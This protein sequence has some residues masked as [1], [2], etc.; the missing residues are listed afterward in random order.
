LVFNKLKINLFGE[1]RSF[2]KFDFSIDELELYTAI[3]HKLKIPIHKAFLDPFFYH[4]LG[5]SSISNF[6]D[7]KGITLKGLLNSPKNQIEIWFKNKKV[8]KLA[9][10]TFNNEY[11]LFLLYKS[12]IIEITSEFKEGIYVEQKEF[13][14]IGSYEFIL[15][16]EFNIEN[17]CF[18][19][20]NFD[21]KQIL[22]KITFCNTIHLN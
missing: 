1:R 2:K 17:L 13:G 18:H 7:L 12:E 3:S 22:N 6:E 20:M 16:D 10:S 11:L 8:Q 21:N 14:F 5:N 4:F 19:L 9:M 15:E